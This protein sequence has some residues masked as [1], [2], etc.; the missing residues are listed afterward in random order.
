[1]SLVESAGVR[2][3]SNL[4]MTNIHGMCA[5]IFFERYMKH[6]I[7]STKGSSQLKRDKVK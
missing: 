4:E 1:M 2:I 6:L 3:F 7:R 5:Y